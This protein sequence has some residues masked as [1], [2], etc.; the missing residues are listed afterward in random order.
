MGKTFAI[1]GLRAMGLGSLADGQVSEVEA[2]RRHAGRG[3]VHLQMGR[4]QKRVLGPQA[5]PNG[6]V[7]LQ[8]GRCQKALTDRILAA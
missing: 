3:W 7:H 6:W 4:C 2:G 5:C 1:K 8:M